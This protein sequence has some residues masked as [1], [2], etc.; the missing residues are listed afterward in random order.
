MADRSDVHAWNYVTQSGAQITVHSPRSSYVKMAMWGML[1][2]CLCLL[3]LALTLILWAAMQIGKAEAD[4]ATNPT[5]QQGEVAGE[6]VV[7]VFVGILGL[8]TAYAGVGCFRIAR[9]NI[10][11]SAEAAFRVGQRAP[12]VYLRSFAQD[13]MKQELQTTDQILHPVQARVSATYE[14]RFAKHLRKI[15]PM[16]AIGKPGEKLPP[17]GAARMYV[18]NAHWQEL[19]VDLLHRARVVVIQAGST[20]GI[21]WEFSTAIER[22]AP[23]Q[24]LVF[25]PSQLSLAKHPRAEAYRQF[26]DWASRDLPTELPETIDDAAVIRFLDTPP[27]Q[28]EPLSRRG[29]R[30]REGAM[31]RCLRRLVRDR[32]LRPRGGGLLRLVIYVLL[33]LLALFLIVGIIGAI[34]LP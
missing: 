25:L 2:A 22:L 10:A 32:Y 13:N 12:V 23:S 15:G 17:T 31:D 11:E 14:E 30:V 33:G 6:A 1:G 8:S 24:L 16:V 20:P 26:R 28:P 9:R 29:I 34:F 19:V 5:E 7:C 21:Q 18:E 4:S 27:W 3:A